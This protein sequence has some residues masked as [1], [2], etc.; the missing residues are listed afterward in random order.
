MRIII[1]AFKSLVVIKLNVVELQGDG[2][3][4]GDGRTSLVCRIRFLFLVLVF[5]FEIVSFYS[6]QNIR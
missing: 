6:K 1:D 5:T 4:G 3:G 2:G